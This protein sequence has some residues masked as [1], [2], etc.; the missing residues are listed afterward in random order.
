MMS[1]TESVEAYPLSGNERS[2]P[3]VMRRGNV[4]HRPDGP[5]TDLMAALLNHLTAV[6]FEHS[7]A[8]MGR[9][10]VGRHM[11]EFVDG[12]VWSIPPWVQDDHANAEAMGQVAE[13][14]RQL[15]DATA[16]FIPPLG[17]NPVRPLPVP[18]AT[19]SHGDI[20]YPNIVFRSGQPVAFI[21]WEFVAPA[22]PVCDPAG[23]LALGVRG[24]RPGA[25]DH[26]RRV[27]AFKLACHAIVEGYGSDR[28]DA[29]ELWSATASVLE[30]AAGYW[31]S[32][33]VDAERI[34]A[35]RWRANWIRE[36]QPSAS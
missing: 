14:I 21:D 29:E 1:D 3:P 5:G 23:L 20:G 7:P 16:T 24:P 15:H 11:V 35:T 6:G 36:N 10:G 9:D 33:R 28:F 34:T 4:V 32:L 27:D 17:L 2:G 13:L 19:W 25:G 8:Y 31:E 22:H 30:D 26:A 18:G 12:D